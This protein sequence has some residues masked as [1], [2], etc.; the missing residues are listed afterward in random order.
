MKADNLSR[1]SIGDEIQVSK[2]FIERNVGDIGYPKFMGMQWR[3]ILYQVGIAI[4]EMFG[5]GSKGAAVTLTHQHFIFRQQI[6]QPIT[7]NAQVIVF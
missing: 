7:A 4:K 3:E 5:V 6:K 2:T 1:V